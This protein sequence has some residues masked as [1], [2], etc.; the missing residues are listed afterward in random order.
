[1]ANDSYEERTEPATEKKRSD[2][3]EKG[4]VLKS[5]ELNSAMVLVFGLMILYFAGATLASQLAGIAR[6]M[7]GMAGSFQPTQA[8]VHRLFV[9]AAFRMVVTIA[10]V[11]IGMMIVGVLSNL[12][13]VGFVFSPESMMPTADK[14]NPLKGFQRILL[15]RRSMVEM[16]KNLLKIVIVGVAGYLALDSVLGQSM[17]LMDSDP[18]AML[19]F[20][21]TAAAS[22]AFKTGLAFLV[23]AGAD[24]FYQRWEFERDMKMTK[25]ELKEELRSTEGD[26][27]VK[28]KVREIQRRIAYRRMMHEVPTAS[29]VITNPTHVAVALR[30]DPIAMDAPRVVAKG[31][32]L[33]AQKI[34]EVAREHGV[35]I[36]EDQPLARTLYKSVEIGH[37]I[38]EKLF[39]AVAQVLAYIYRLK[40]TRPFAAVS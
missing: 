8:A 16:L 12:V 14:I 26:P 40:K 18:A 3:R 6:T 13:Q 2:A 27:T 24:Y 15:S 20:I 1:M 30:Y 31:A 33:V 17:T 5:A 19:G 28:G 10:P 32:E 37:V 21:G 7:F 38:P 4:K 36:V 35:P 23:L 22:V 11:V 39:Q 9:D 29:V 25:Q 34:K